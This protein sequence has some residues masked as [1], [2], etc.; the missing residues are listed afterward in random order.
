MYVRKVVKGNYKNFEEYVYAE[1]T[2]EMIK[3]MKPY[4]GK[5]KP[6]TYR[7]LIRC[8]HEEHNDKLT[9]YRFYDW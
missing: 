4:L 8:L 9:K 1:T 2:E 5:H 6:K 7:G 3:K